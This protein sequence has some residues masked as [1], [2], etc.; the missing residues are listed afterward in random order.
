MTA[1]AIEGPGLFL[2]RRI[3]DSP[4]LLTRVGLFHLD[5]SGFLVTGEGYRVQGIMHPNG[6]AMGDLRVD[7]EQPPAGAD[8]SAGI[9]SFEIGADGQVWLRL[10]DGTIYSR[11]RILL[12][13]VDDC[14]AL[15][16]SG[17]G[18]YR[19][20]VAAVLVQL[21]EPGSGARGT[22]RASAR[23]FTSVPPA[24]LESVEIAPWYWQGQLVRTN[25]TGFA[26]IA[27]AGFFQV[28][29]P[30]DG[31]I[32]L[33]RDGAF[34]VSPEGWLVTGRGLRVQGWSDSVLTVMGDLRVDGAGRPATSD[35]AAPW[36][37]WDL[38][39]G[40]RI[41]VRLADGT[42]YVRAQVLLAKVRWPQHLHWLGNHLFAATAAA[43]VGGELVEP[44]IGGL[45][46]VQSRALEILRQPGDERCSMRLVGEPGIELLVEA[47]EDWFV[48]TEVARVVPDED[49]G[50]QFTDPI[51]SRRQRFYRLRGPTRPAE[52]A[53]AR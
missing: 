2:V 25:V 44:G 30:E 39:R 1:L 41:W 47:S 10:A 31:S 5:P 52:G 28:R 26:A 32:L 24:F 23:E 3:A 42:E 36:T 45:G 13:A 38:D 46:Q 29:D 17:V 8:P 18:L 35:P 14:E 6:T 49:Y 20:A 53:P 50:G 16:R 34:R 7:N 33:T 4:F 48:W 21:G 43:E 15:A 51:G 37:G 9:E 27:G 19:P 11:A 22:L 12:A 40:G